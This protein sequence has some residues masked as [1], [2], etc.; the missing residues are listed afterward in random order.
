MAF[1]S[2]A[3]NEDEENE[4]TGM[5][6]VSSAQS[7]NIDGGGGPAQGAQKGGSGQF[8]NIQDYIKANQ[9]KT[10][11]LSEGITSGVKKKGQ[12][13]QGQLGKQRESLLGAQGQFGQGQQDFVTNQIQQAGQ[14]G[15]TAEDVK[16]FRDIA[17]GLQGPDLS[18][19]RLQA[20]DLQRQAKEFGTSKGRQ[21]GLARTVGKR[22]PTY[23]K[24]QRQLD[25]LLLAGDRNKGSSIRGVKEATKGLGQQVEQLGTDVG[26]AR[27]GLVDSTTTGLTGAQQQITDARTAQQEKFKNMKLGDS[28]SQEDLGV[29]GRE[30]GYD[31]LWGADAGQ[32]IEGSITPEQLKRADALA[33]LQGKAGSGLGSDFYSTA[34]LDD[35]IG[36]NQ[37]QAYRDVSG[38]LKNLHGSGGGVDRTRNRKDAQY[39]ASI[40]GAGDYSRQSLT[41]NSPD[42][43]Y[44]SSRQGILDQFGTGEGAG[45]N[46]G[47]RST[48]EYKLSNL[49]DISKYDSA[50]GLR[51]ALR[52]YTGN[53]SF[54]GTYV[55]PSQWNQFGNAGRVEG[56][57]DDI[58]NLLGKYN[59]NQGIGVEPQ[60]ADGGVIGTSGYSEDQEYKKGGVVE[61]PKMKAL[62]K[63]RGY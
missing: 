26:T 48:G 8:T 6:A 50:E 58:Q 63:M 56:R 41:R 4:E 3:P 13:L 10:S 9:P 60:V 23:A 17:G 47:P 42:A 49:E 33:R 36:N 38:Y 44:N 32:L 51:G 28:F 24:G 61:C 21:E 27:Q 34:N 7:S 19:Q 52:G 1:L 55:Q 16:K 22:S 54:D 43:A 5:N 20:Q 46:F 40:M 12:E 45:F 25:Q 14:G 18:K 31:Q 30:K 15:Q 62:R 35:T 39:L 37:Q 2:S 57:Y 29:L 59:L 11:A 53:R